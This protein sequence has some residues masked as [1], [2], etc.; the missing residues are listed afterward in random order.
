M[1]TRNFIPLSFEQVM[2]KFATEDFPVLL[3]DP[4]R[5]AAAR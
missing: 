5:R 1:K 3:R 2:D 4:L